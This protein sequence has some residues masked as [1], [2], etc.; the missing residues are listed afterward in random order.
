[1]SQATEVGQILGGLRLSVERRREALRNSD[2]L[3]R[4]LQASYSSLITHDSSLPVKILLL[5]QC[6]YP[7]VMATAQHLTDLAV[8]LQ[9]EGHEVSVVTGDRG[10]DNPSQRFPRYEVWNGIQITRISSM[11]LG[12]KS[13]WRRA[14]N[15]AS[16]LI[17][18]SLRLLLLP[19]FDV[20]VALTSP[21]LI[22][23]LGS[24]FVR[25]KGG[26]FF[27][28]VMDLNPDEAVAVGWLRRDS[29]SAQVLS[30][31]LHYSLRHSER[32]IALD[33]FMKE[34]IVA[35]GIAETS[36]V[37][38]PP[39]SHDD[40]VRFDQAGREAF[41]RQHHLDEKFVVMYAGNHSP[42]HP[43]DTLVKAARVL[44][45][46]K[47]IVFCFVGGGSEQQKVKDFASENQ[48]ANILCLPYQPFELLSAS[49]SAADLHAVVMGDEFVGIVHPCK[50]YNILTIG[51]PFVYTGPRPS[52]VTEI[53]AEI[54][55]NGN[56]SY[57]A[58]VAGSRDVETVITSVLEEAHLTREGVPSA[59]PDIANLFS[60]ETL[61]RQMIK[62]LQSQAI[63]ENQV[64]SSSESSGFLSAGR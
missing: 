26:K 42:C 16:F 57:R 48:L 29:L 47:D 12:K 4:G 44:S 63:V 28:W 58:Y 49:L 54:S 53:A 35:K 64:F 37:V 18:C 41:R 61:L 9:R 46:R 33:H 38:L 45:R 59:P 19:R 20:V 27:F 34:R 2:T 6:F 52:H 25:I 15:F 7:D 24:V 13:R 17:N 11:A 50:L 10:Y 56:S 3:P 14:V 21:P 23:F 43:L 40:T 30:R 62:L 55:A 32:I 36:V 22:S 1:M 8:G 60:K 51:I 39:W 31:L 5:N